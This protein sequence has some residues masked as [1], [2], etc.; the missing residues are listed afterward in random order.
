MA[1]D[2]LDPSTRSGRAVEGKKTNKP[3]GTITVLAGELTRAL[4]Q[5]DRLTSGRCEMPI[6]AMVRMEARGD[7]LHL[8]A[9]DLD[10]CAR[11]QVEV[12]G[13]R[14][15][16]VPFALCVSASKLYEVCEKLPKGEPVRLQVDGQS[17]CERLRVESRGAFGPILYRF[18]ILAAADFPAFAVVK[19]VSRFALP[20][21]NL[22]AAID[23]VR[24][25]ISTEET[26]YYLNGIF[27]HVRPNETG[28]PQLVMAAT[29]GQRLA[30]WRGA[31]PDGAAAMPD[32][33]IAR[34]TI[35]RLTGL[36]KQLKGREADECDVDIE[37]SAS[38]IAFTIGKARLDCKLIDGTYPDYERVIP[39]NNDR[40]ALVNPAHLAGAVKQ[41]VLM[42]SEKTRCARC[43]FDPDG[44]VTVSMQS[45][46]NGEA[47]ARTQC[48]YDGEAM[49]IGWNS[50][51][52]LDILGRMAGESCRISMATP[53]APTHI[54]AQEGASC[55]YTLMPMRV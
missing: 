32:A 3:A 21:F 47:E 36:I 26:R 14:A 40:L 35:E 30:R 11:D 6:L 39:A 50:A 22:H 44:S 16:V 51:Y 54:I 27:F 15:E 42:G 46:E 45:P 13:D 29:D 12:H 53:A 37:V 23:A 9:T 33:I 7:G 34:R 5:I 55:D 24:H 19:P 2:V 49:T 41:V 43:S 38:K 25:A 1:T 10:M 18:P 28:D 8:M 17:G 48:D 20:A 52:L 31:V 4:E